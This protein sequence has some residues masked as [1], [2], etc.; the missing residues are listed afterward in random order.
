MITITAHDDAMVAESLV[1][2]EGLEA[3][4]SSVAPLHEVR[5][6]S[7]FARAPDGQVIGGALG[8]TWGRCCELLELW[9]HQDHRGTKIGLQL[10]RA[11]E[12]Q[13]SSRGC[14]VF[15]LTTFSFQAPDFYRRLGYQVQATVSGF[16]G[17]IAK[18]TMVKITS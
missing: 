8:R 1:V 4:N 13:A 11:F 9:V 6:L 12:A 2:S 10:V 5:P 3:F 17:D 18:H 7:C 15:Y 16:S 14:N